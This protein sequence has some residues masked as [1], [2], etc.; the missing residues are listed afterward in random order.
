MIPSAQWTTTKE[1][2][3]RTA[4]VFVA[5]TGTLKLCPPSKI[6]AQCIRHNSIDMNVCQIVTDMHRTIAHSLVLNDSVLMLP[7]EEGVRSKEFPFLF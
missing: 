6:P 1:I 7:K 3:K 5:T 2:H 4:V